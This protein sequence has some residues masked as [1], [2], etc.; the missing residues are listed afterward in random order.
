[1]NELCIECLL[2]PLQYSCIWVRMLLVCVY[3][4]SKDGTGLS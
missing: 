1:M 4:I 3:N 2:S